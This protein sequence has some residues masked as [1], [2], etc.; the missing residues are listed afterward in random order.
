MLPGRTNAAVKNFWYAYTRRSLKGAPGGADDVDVGLG[1]HSAASDGGGGGEW[2]PA[3][4]LGAR[5]DRNCSEGFGDEEDLGDEDLEDDCD[6]EE[7]G[8]EDAGCDE[9]G[10]L[11]RHGL[12][13]YDGAIDARHLLGSGQAWGAGESG[14]VPA[15]LSD[16]P[17]DGGIAGSSSSP[18]PPLRV[19]LGKGF[20][21]AGV[22]RRLAWQLG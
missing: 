19:K 13:A 15:A 14:I 18:R 6:A 9:G 22:R 11:Q 12:I 4:V 1:Y 5:D 17:S 16:G 8:E 7:E 10:S 20:K 2:G 21:A 3:A